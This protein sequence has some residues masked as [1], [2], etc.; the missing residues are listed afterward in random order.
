[1]NKGANLQGRS[2]KIIST[3]LMKKLRLKISMDLPLKPCRWD[4]VVWV[5]AS[6]TG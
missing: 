3:L 1:M 6:Q 2:V 4:V 5:L